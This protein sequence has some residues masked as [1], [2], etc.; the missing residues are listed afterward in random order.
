MN[1]SQITEPREKTKTSGGSAGRIWPLLTLPALVV[2]LATVVVASFLAGTSAPSELGD[3]GP[4]VRWALP[5]AKALHHSSMAITI[6]ALV[7][8][9]TILPRSTKPKRAGQGQHDTDGGAPHPAFV[10]SM[11][12][13]AAAGLVWTMSAAAVLIFS[14][15]DLVGKPM[16]LDSTYT[17]AMLDFVLEISVGRAWAWMIVIAAIT[18]SLAFGVRSPAWLGFSA[19]FSLVSVLPLSLIGHAAGG[20]DHWGAVNAIG[21]HLL[22]VS[23]W[24]G[25]IAVLAALAPLLQDRAPGRHG[26]TTPILAGVVLRRFSALATISIFLVAGSGLVST[27]IRVTSWS[28][29]N[30]PYGWL[31]IAKTLST[32]G[33]G[34][35]GLAHRRYVIPRL[36]SGS[37]GALNAAWRIVGLE[38]L[39]MAAVMSLGTVLGRTAPPTPDTP[40]ELPSPARLLSGYELP[41][42]LTANSWLTVWRFDWLWV[43][44]IILL[45]AM[46]IIAM[47]KVRRRGDTWP[48]LRL[49]AWIV[50]LVALFY[51]TSG[52][53][54]VYGMVLFSVH[55]VDHMAL[56]M[57]APL[58]MVM[59]APVTLALKALPPR[60]D[61]T[62]GPREWILVLVHS[63]YSAFITH[64]L[65]AA[66][67][68]AGSII[69]FYGTDLFAYALR[70]HVGHEL[71]N[72]HFLLTGYLFAL[73][74]IGSDP[75]PKRA[76][77]PLRLVI[78]LATMSFH[79]FYGVSLMSSTSLIQADWFG[80]LGRPWG[81]SAIEDQRLG[82]A[83]MWGIGEVPT[84]LL[85]LGVMVAWSR[86][87]A[88]ETKRKDRQADRDNDAE[89]NAYNEMFA[90]LNQHDQEIERRGR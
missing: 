72:V 32:L 41:P 23:L 22:G 50:G 59:G 53:P 16:S 71:M 51:I 75:V 2:G 47:I 81:D 46:Y 12:L 9:A 30:S 3:P 80:N 58:F 66:A 74:M 69:I 29:L 10:R 48:I 86:D 37:F 1:K 85:A 52:A 26:R 65:F 49:A 78:L 36:E 34:A 14:F 7:F 79:A 13:A 57:V 39:I 11:N 64:P 17:A 20:D 15:W 60:T 77:Y 31:V 5:V 82:A 28:Q 55:M 90:Q 6:A 62:R 84:L 21:L 25:G 24:F 87:D 43:A 56:T 44:I 70:S 88:R 67:N 4:L 42:E 40:P 8:A 38:A 73:S 54:A 83:A 27:L 89:L 33:L 45:A 63:K 18:A 61:G 68:F 19:A 35:L 76:P